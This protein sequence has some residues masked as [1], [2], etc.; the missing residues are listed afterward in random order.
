MALIEA[1]TQASK[2]QSD[3]HQNLKVAIVGSE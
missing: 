1:K 3:D 2:N